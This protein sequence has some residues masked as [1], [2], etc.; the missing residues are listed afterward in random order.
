M[1]KN[2]S[3]FVATTASQI[4]C[5][6]SWL[7]HEP[8]AIRDNG[9]SCARLSAAIAAIKP[10][11]SQQERARDGIFGTPDPLACGGFT[12]PAF[13]SIMNCLPATLRRGTHGK[14]DSLPPKRKDPVLPIASIKA[15]RRAY[16]FSLAS[17][18]GFITLLAILMG[19][20]RI[21]VLRNKANFCRGWASQYAD[22]AEECRRTADDPNLTVDEASAWR[23]QAKRKEII[24]RK[25]Q[26]VAD[27]P[28]LPYPRYP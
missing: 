6:R 24:A 8:K 18:L 15:T 20:W 2:N 17:M 11:A 1:N 4:G 23:L 7:A 13:L 25:Y 14:H 3:G 10:T 27:R 19:G 22:E 28:W 21:V 12:E 16:Q 9:A 5:G 26:N